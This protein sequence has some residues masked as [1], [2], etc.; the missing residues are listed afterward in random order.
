MNNNIAVSIVIPCYN[1]QDTI[2]ETLESIVNQD[3]K[4]FEIIIVNDGSKDGSQ[5]L[6]EEYR[7]NSKYQI[8]LINQENSGPSFARNNGAS[9]AKGKYLL[10]IDADDKIAPSYISECLAIFEN[11]PDAVIVYSEIEL[12]EA[13]SGKW[14]LKDFKL[15][16]F[17]IN[18]CIPICGMMETEKFKE[19]G[20]FDTEISFT[21]DWELWIRFIQKYGTG[22]YK[23]PKLL[24]FYRK[25][26]NQNSLTDTKG[27]NEYGEKCRLYIYNKH[28][29]FYRKNNLSLDNLL[30]YRHNYYKIHK[31]YY[32]IWYKKLFASLKKIVSNKK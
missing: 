3:F 17:L 14:E 24:F 7:S 15:P 21:E 19:I 27:H 22:V 28:Y 6:I 26:F 13:E 32:N 11:K 18:N 30:E 12:F 9:S 29:D 1:N 20:G 31:K 23:I 25:R 8:T 10:F 4:N 5:Q 2:E 16:D